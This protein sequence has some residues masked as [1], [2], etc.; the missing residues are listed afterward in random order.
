VKYSFFVPIGAAARF[1]LHPSDNFFTNLLPAP[2]TFRW[3]TKQSFVH[4]HKITPC[5]DIGVILIDGDAHQCRRQSG[6]S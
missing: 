3:A 4:E 5:R 1:A 6:R 2:D